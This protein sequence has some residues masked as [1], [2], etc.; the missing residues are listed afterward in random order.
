MDIPRL[1]HSV[2][3]TCHTQAMAGTRPRVLPYLQMGGCCWQAV[4]KLR[5]RLDVLQQFDK[6]AVMQMLHADVDVD[7]CAYLLWK[8]TRNAGAC[9]LLPPSSSS[10]P[11]T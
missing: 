2:L 11:G 10:T 7:K 1:P 3:L 4:H 8:R 5:W 6:A 9:V